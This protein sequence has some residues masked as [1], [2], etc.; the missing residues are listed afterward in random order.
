M[1]EILEVPVNLEPKIIEEILP[2]QE[3]WK[4]KLVQRAID[5]AKTLDG[6]P[7]TKGAKKLVG[8]GFYAFC[9]VIYKPMYPMTVWMNRPIDINNDEEKRDATCWAAGAGALAGICA[10]EIPLTL[11]NSAW[12]G[13]TIIPV[14]AVSAGIAGA[15]AYCAE[16]KRIDAALKKNNHNL[17]T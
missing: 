13:P 7:I 17:P 10:T 11:I 6:L 3:T 15:F 2:P 8:K 16:T 9:W 12:V 5:S 4:S 1:V 14:A